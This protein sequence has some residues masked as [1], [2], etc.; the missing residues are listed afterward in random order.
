MEV[1]DDHEAVVGALRVRRA[2]P[3]RERRTVG[4]WCFADHMGPA[5]ISATTGVDIAPHPHTGLQTVT[6]LLD[7][8]LLHR[9]SLGSE[10]VIRPGQLNLM[11]A[12]HGVAHSEEN[13]GAFRGSL[14]GVQLWIAQPESTRHGP[15]EFAHIAAPPEAELDGVGGRGD[16]HATVL[17]G[18]WGGLTSP[19]RHDSELA[20]VELSVLGSAEVPLRAD[21]EWALLVLTGAVEIGKQ[22]LVP[23]RF[24]YLGLRRE[25]LPLRARERSRVLLI[26]GRPFAERISMW[27]NF[28]GRSHEELSDAR[29]A[30]QNG[31][32]ER[33]G[34]VASPLPALEAPPT[35]WAPGR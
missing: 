34:R 13:T 7:G 14:H 20:G 33:F 2:L 9:D 17:V 23:G 25:V 27:W 3:R 21:F 11:T 1:W 5:D 30:W 31:E 24:G 12:G 22:P 26:G 8:E 15:A 19:A 10:Q 29:A 35:P 16:G 28:V 6:W 18:T 4:A 32:G